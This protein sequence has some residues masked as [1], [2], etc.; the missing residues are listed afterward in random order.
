M[1]QSERTSPI[2]RK[3]RLS[4]FALALAIL[5]PASFAREAEEHPAPVGEERS[6]EAD[7]MEAP[8]TKKSEASV[9]AVL[10]DASGDV[11]LISSNRSEFLEVAPKTSVPCGSWVSTKNGWA[12]LRFPNGAGIRIGQASFAQVFPVGNASKEPVSLYRGTVLVRSSGDALPFGVLSANGRAKSASGTMIVQYDPTL[13]E[14]RVLALDRKAEFEN[15][16]LGSKPMTVREGELSDLNF[17]LMRTIP[18]QPKPL[19]QANAREIL[20]RLDLSQGEVKRYADLVRQRARRQVV[21]PEGRAADPERFVASEPK[22]LKA[23]KSDP[24]RHGSTVESL[25]IRKLVGEEDGGEKLVR[26]KRSPASVKG[27]GVRYKVEVHQPSKG[28]ED[29]KS[30]VLKALSGLSEED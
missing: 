6:K 27:K 15:R 7:K 22:P 13:E 21:L 12:D 3:R 29:E 1:G 17:K 23:R 24:G 10:D 20:E 26:T 8:K 19:K 5:H 25:M 14:T 28:V 4:A 2:F 30:R 18:T 9:C 11:L 16:Y